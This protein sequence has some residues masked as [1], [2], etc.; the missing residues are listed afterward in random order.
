MDAVVRTVIHNMYAWTVTTKLR[1]EMALCMITTVASL[2][3][4]PEHCSNT[5]QSSPTTRRIVIRE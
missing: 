1:E 4:S 3:I 5:A 2:F